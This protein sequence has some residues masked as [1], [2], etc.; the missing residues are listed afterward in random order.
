MS[1]FNEIPNLN[2]AS[3]VIHLTGLRGGMR[4][5]SFPLH[6]SGEAAQGPLI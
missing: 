3:S 1:S 2:A 5:V 6:Q 4:Q